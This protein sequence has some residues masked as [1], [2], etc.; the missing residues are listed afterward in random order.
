[1][2]KA[3]Y[4]GDI[5]GPLSSPSDLKAISYAR[6]KKTPLAKGPG[7]GFRPLEETSCKEVKTVVTLL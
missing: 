3:G 4:G 5:N 1:M 7:G 6:V 2:L